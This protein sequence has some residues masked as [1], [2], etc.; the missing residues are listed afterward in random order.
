MEFPI[1]NHIYV[2][3]LIIQEMVTRP[4]LRAA[5]LSTTEELYI[6]RRNKRTTIDGLPEDYHDE[7]QS[8]HGPTFRWKCIDV[9]LGRSLDDA[10][11]IEKLVE[12]LQTNN[13]NVQRRSRSYCRMA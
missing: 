13:S 12:P 8:S 1:D 11:V 3:R 4:I 7:L 10:L 2:G 6:I 9:F 5:F